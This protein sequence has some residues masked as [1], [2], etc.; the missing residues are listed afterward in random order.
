MISTAQFYSPFSPRSVIP[1]LSR[2]A[3]WPGRVVATGLR[4]DGTGALRSEPSR[5]GSPEGSD[6]SDPRG[7]DN[8]SPPNDNKATST[9]FRL[10]A[11]EDK[12]Q[13]QRTPSQ[14]P[15]RSWVG[16]A[17]TAVASLGIGIA[18]FT[19]ELFGKFTEVFRVLATGVGL[20]CLTSLGGNFFLGVSPSDSSPASDSQDLTNT[21][22]NVISTNSGDSRSFSH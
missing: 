12:K 8:T 13:M 22:T 17:L 16:F 18:A 15:D 6:K 1:R 10:T 11:Q 7:S 20:V 5:A 3:S 2:Y 9:R 19:T 21:A 4:F 14:V